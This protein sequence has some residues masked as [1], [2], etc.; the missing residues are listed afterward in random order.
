MVI[1]RSGKNVPFLGKNI[2][3][4][5]QK[6]ATQLLSEQHIINASLNAQ[7]LDISMTANSMESVNSGSSKN[8]QISTC[9]ARTSTVSEELELTSYSTINDT[10]MLS[11]SDQSTMIDDTLEITNYDESQFMDQ[12]NHY[13]TQSLAIGHGHDPRAS[14]HSGGTNTNEMHTKQSNLCSVADLSWF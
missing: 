13:C 6:K 7:N 1:L 3:K 5:N 12:S 2:P 9:S 8:S 10:S 4:R 14:I 11:N